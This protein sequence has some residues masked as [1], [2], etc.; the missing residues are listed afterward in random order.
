TRAAETRRDLLRADIDRLSLRKQAIVAQLESL[1]VL[2]TDSVR[3]F[4][5]RPDAAATA[6]PVPET[7][8]EPDAGPADDDQEE[9]VAE[10]EA[11][12]AQA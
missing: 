5:D 12:G 2:A 9:L 6:D 8:D 10:P 7:T 3:D 4:P 11:A 1:S